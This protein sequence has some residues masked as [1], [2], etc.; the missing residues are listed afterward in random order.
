MFILLKTLSV[1]AKATLFNVP[2]LI[3]LFLKQEV[4]IAHN[5]LNIPLR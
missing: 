5:N 1:L 4:N 3:G 2:E